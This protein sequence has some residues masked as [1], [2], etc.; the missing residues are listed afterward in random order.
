MPPEQSI[1]EALP[2]VYRRVLDAVDALERLGGRAEAARLRQSA[3][4]AYARSWDARNQ[5]RIEA[6]AVRAELAVELQRSS[7]PHAA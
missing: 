5:R 6:I 3:V 2:R 7:G 4:A 1:A